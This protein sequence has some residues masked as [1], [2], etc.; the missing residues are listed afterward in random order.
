VAAAIIAKQIDRDVRPCVP[1]IDI[2]KPPRPLLE[3]T[4]RVVRQAKQFSK[5][6]AHGIKRSKDI[7]KQLLLEGSTSIT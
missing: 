4:S 3:S 6:I 1:S 2:S 5:E 7:L